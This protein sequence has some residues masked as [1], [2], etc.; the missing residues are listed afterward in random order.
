MLCHIVQAYWKQNNSM[1][2]AKKDGNVFY[3]LQGLNNVALQYTFTLTFISNNQHKLV[4]GVILVF[5]FQT[6]T[7]ILDALI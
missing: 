7:W 6:N 1:F 2:I 3:S 5:V 4:D